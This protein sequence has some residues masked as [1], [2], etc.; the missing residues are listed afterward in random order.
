MLKRFLKSN[1]ILI[2]LLVLV[3]VLIFVIVG[4]IP[5][6][7][8]LHLLLDRYIRV[9][10]LLSGISVTLGVIGLFI[11]HLSR[12][13]IMKNNEYNVING[14]MIRYSELL[15][16]LSDI[17]NGVETNDIKVRLTLLNY[18]NLSEEQLFQIG[19]EMIPK[20]IGRIWIKGI[21]E[22]INTFF[23]LQDQNR[24]DNGEMIEEY[25][26]EYIG[27]DSIYPLLNLLWVKLQENP[28]ETL[29]NLSKLITK[30]VKQIS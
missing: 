30:K 7:K 24:D 12:K 27:D 26:D 9:F 20:G 22:Q 16:K 11:T 3:F 21:K 29:I 1:N 5:S 13:D 19:K 25:V 4:L 17:E 18:Y 28:D 10:T 6:N 15:P 14:L 23:D 8:F 2:F